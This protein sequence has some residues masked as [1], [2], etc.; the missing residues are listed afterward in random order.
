MYISN[1][2]LSFT[3]QVILKICSF[4]FPHLIDSLL[5]SSQQIRNL[6]ML[7]MEDTDKF[8]RVR[9]YESFQHDS[10]LCLVFEML[11]Q[12]LY[13]FMDGRDWSPP[14][15]AY[16]RPTVKQVTTAM[17]K[18]KSLGIIHTDLKPDNIMLADPINQL[19]IV[20]LYRVKIIN[21]SSPTHVSDITGKFYW[22]EWK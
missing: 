20:Y 16:I 13:N 14:K 12:S 4:I 2:T 6:K 18:L 15:T 10:Q 5:F 17:N 11:R 8:N 21:F 19:C 9:W 1:D 7:A 3:I 22:P